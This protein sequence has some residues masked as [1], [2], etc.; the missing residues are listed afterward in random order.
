MKKDLED[1][2]LQVSKS[3]IIDQ[4]DLTQSV[5]T[6]LDSA[7]EGLQVKRAGVWFLEDNSSAIQCVL[8]KDIANNTELE[9]ARLTEKDYP[10]YFAALKTERAIMAN[11][12]QIDD[13]TAEFTDGYLKPLGIES[14]LDVPIR[15]RGVMVGIICCEHIGPARQWTED[16][17]TFAAALADLVGRGINAR[18]YQKAAE[19]LENANLELEQRVNLRTQELEAALKNLQNT[20]EQLIESEKLAA[21]GGLVSGVA[22]EVNTPLGV[23]ITAI[24]HLDHELNKVIKKYNDGQLDEKAF[25]TFTEEGKEAIS[26]INSNMNRAARLIR[27]FKMTASNQSMDEARKFKLDENINALISSLHPVT[28]A[29]NVKIVCD[30]PAEISV[31]NHPGSLSQALTNLIINSTTHAFNTIER[32]LIDIHVESV[33]DQVKLVYRDNGCGISAE[34]LKKI[35]DPFFTTNRGKGGTGLGLSI[36][37]NLV[38]NKLGGKVSVESEPGEGTQ[39]TITFPKSLEACVA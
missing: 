20:Q 21:L 6:V 9:D 18:N 29:A 32:P 39:F 26:I 22:H 14:M 2:L 28:K 31:F 36:L 7:I 4:G 16:E 25:S 12:A 37:H 34:N 33:E 27:D 17:A 10:K 15:H 5:R 11:N 38:T 19:R 24:S 8:V 13:T 23:S 3:P 30:C 35:F 1:I